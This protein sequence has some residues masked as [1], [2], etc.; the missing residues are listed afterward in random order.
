M[1]D[2]FDRGLIR[3]GLFD[4]GGLFDKGFMSKSGI[5]LKG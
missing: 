5:F 3:R 4:G 2:L 1:G